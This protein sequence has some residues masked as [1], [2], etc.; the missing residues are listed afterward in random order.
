MNLNAKENGNE[1]I[2]QKHVVWKYK[3]VQGDCV[4]TYVRMKK[5]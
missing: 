2:L 5:C 3:R 1:Q 4:K